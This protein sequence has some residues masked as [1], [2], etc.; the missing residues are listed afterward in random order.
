M[1]DWV[2]NAPLYFNKFCSDFFTYHLAASQ[3]TLGNHQTCFL[4]IFEKVYE[5]WVETVLNSTWL[6]LN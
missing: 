1:F 3:P 6:L 2:V 4:V 5:A